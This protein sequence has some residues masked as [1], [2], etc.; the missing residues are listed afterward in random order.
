MVCVSTWPPEEHRK[1]AHDFWSSPG[2]SRATGN[3][4]DMFR[5]HLTV[6]TYVY[7]LTQIFE[8]TQ[9]EVSLEFKTKY[10][11]VKVWQRSFK[12][13]KPFFV[14]APRSQD[15]VTCCCR[16]HVK[17]CMLFQT[18]IEFWKQVLATKGDSVYLFCFRTFRNYGIAYQLGR[19]RAQLILGIWKNLPQ[20][21]MNSLRRWEYMLQRKPK[22]SHQS[23]A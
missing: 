16:L 22:D 13:C 17:T 19:S 2:I 15:K 20:N 14:I 23:M 4:K 1:P 6:R 10:W 3:K 11:E 18:C 7:H 21:S 12:R 8:K 9:T 5:K